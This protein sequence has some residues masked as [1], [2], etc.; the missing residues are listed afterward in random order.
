[1]ANITATTG[2][3]WIPVIWSQ[4]TLQAAEFARVLAKLVNRA[5]EGAIE[6]MG[7]TVRIPHT[8]NYT[9]NTKSAGSNLSFEAV[10]H[11]KTDLVINAHQYAAFQEEK[12]AEKQM[13]P[14]YLSVNTKKLGYAL[15]RA[16]DVAIGALFPSL[17]TNVVGTY[18]VE[19][20]DNDYLSAWQ[21]VVDSGAIQG[22]GLAEEVA[23]VLSSAAYVAAMKTEKF[24]NRDY[25]NDGDAVT[26]ATVGV[27]YGTKTYLSLL[28]NV[29]SA[30]QHA[31][32]MF[33]RN[34][35]ACA[36][37][38]GVRMESDFIIEADATAVA[39]HQIYG[40]VTLA[41][42]VETAGSA[43]TSD[44]FATLLRTV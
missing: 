10:T 3:Q 6:E 22:P 33:H 35:F 39:A 14:N 2:A 40:V 26:K 20:T 36:V 41:R 23:T 31:C 4:E 19:L 16:L 17:S 9:A 32:S 13:L 7:N 11:S 38:D 27:I 42:P 18:G 28:L 24:I 25:G 44:A 1:M 12:F 29:P 30:G 43:S 5:Y 21:K 37:Q 8:S 34:A 15:G